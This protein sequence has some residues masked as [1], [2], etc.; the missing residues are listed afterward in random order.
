MQSKNKKMKNNIY[1]F[2]SHLLTLT[3]ITCAPLLL[4]MLL[5]EACIEH[6]IK[7]VQNSIYAKKQNVIYDTQGTPLNIDTLESV[8]F[9]ADGY[10]NIFTDNKGKK[11]RVIFKLGV[12]AFKTKLIDMGYDCFISHIGRGNDSVIVFAEFVESYET[13]SDYQRIIGMTNGKSYIFSLNKKKRIE[14]VLCNDNCKP[15]CYPQCCK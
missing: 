12:R 11:G 8:E 3:L 4:I 9:L 6:D 2:L 7:D 14:E 10:T 13:G 5:C 15:Q 1:L